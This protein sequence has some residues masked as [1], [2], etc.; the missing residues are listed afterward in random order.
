MM[1]NMKH[2]I[3]LCALLISFNSF[4]DA[5]LNLGA[6]YGK[7]Q[8]T[9]QDYV[10]AHMLWNIAAVNGYEDAKGNRDMVAG[11]MTPN[12]IEQAQQLAKEWMEKY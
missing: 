2:L 6:M 8:G 3:L 1:T 7:G 10:M 12:Q 9:P 11:M 5:Q 4:A